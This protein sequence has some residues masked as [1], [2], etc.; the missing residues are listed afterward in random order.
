[1]IWKLFL[2]LAVLFAA[3]GAIHAESIGR[4]PRR[5][6]SPRLP[7]RVMRLVVVVILAVMSIGTAA[8]LYSGWRHEREIILVQVVNANTGQ[9]T[10]YEVRRGSVDGRRFQTLDGREIRLADVERM[11]ILPLNSNTSR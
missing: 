7:S 4:R 3:Y 9:I 1:M 10:P 8:R 2:T 5:Q 6:V 11:I